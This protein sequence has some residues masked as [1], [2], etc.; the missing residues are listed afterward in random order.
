M[1][2]FFMALVARIVPER[3]RFPS[4]AQAFAPFVSVRVDGA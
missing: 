2:M 3:L 4:V 1:P